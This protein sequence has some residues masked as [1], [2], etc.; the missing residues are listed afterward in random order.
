MITH[1]NQE[2]ARSLLAANRVGRLGCIYEGAPYVVPINYVWDGE[3]IYV[4]S[5]PGRKIEALRTD[6]RVCLQVEKVTDASHWTSA[7]VYGTY[8]EVTDP[9]ERNYAVRKLLACFPNLTPVES[10]PVHD[11]QSSVVIFRIRVREITGVGE[12]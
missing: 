4:H 10:V 5:R 3:T 9:S 1:L 8:E 11:G 2:D 7:I 6:P 12:R